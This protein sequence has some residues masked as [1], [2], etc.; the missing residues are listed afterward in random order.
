MAPYTPSENDM[1]RAFFQESTPGTTV[2]LENIPPDQLCKETLGRNLFPEGSDLCAAN[3]ASSFKVNFPTPTTALIQFDSEDRAKSVVSS[4]QVAARL[5]KLGKYPVRMF[6]ARRNL[7]HQG[8]D[9]TAWNREIRTPGAKLI[10]DGDMPSKYFYQSHA[11]A[12]MLRNLDRSS[13]TKESLTEFFQ[14]YSGTFRD[15]KGS[16][17]FIDCLGGLPTD[18]AYVGF[19]RLGEAEAVMQAFGGYA[20]IGNTRVVMKLV[21]DRG[22][23][24][25]PKRV[26]RPERTEEEL[27]KSL[28]DWE[29]YVDQEDIKYLEKHGVAKV[30]IDEA[31]RGL[32]FQNRSFGALDWAMR[33]EKLEPEKESG[34]DY[35]EMVQMYIETLKECIATPENPGDIFE[36]MHFPDEPI[37]MTIFDREKKRTREMLKKRGL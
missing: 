15:E 32:R 20:R 4:D 31:L 35:K 11:G 33:D 14:P 3:T 36:G 16:I 29:Q 5:E 37:D 7:V 10:V 1:K 34:D 22:L 25:L 23:P 27:M 13:V 26:S 24:G 12:I 21:K 30:F 6:K 8:M 17:E 28:N 18:R 9:G 2:I 19:D